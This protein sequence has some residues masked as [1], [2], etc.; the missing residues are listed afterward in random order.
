MTG[1]PGPGA[2]AARPARAVFFG[3]GPFGLAVLEAVRGHPGLSLVAVVSTPDRPSGRRAEPTP[4]PVSRRALELGLPLL[5]PERLR[6]PEATGA[7]AALAADLGVLADYGRI[8]PPAILDLP[9]HGILNVHPSLLP[10]HRGASPIAAAVLAADREAGVTVIRMDEGV[11]S[12]PILAAATIALTGTETAPELEA[13]LAD[14]GA[15]LFSR[16]VGRWLTGELTAEPQDERA[17]TMT[18]PFR[19]ADGAL[20]PT[21]PA[22]EL[23][24]RVRALAPW[25]GTFVETSQGRLLVD[26][27]TV[28]PAMAGDVAGT[29]VAEDAGLALATVDGRL[30]LDEVRLS[31]ARRMTGAELRRGRRALVGARALREGV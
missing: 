14:V 5:R 23:E 20:D 7:I 2:A 13:C 15:T 11:D 29:I 8:V 17:A 31:G 27:A 21:R 28:R 26:R 6:S 30:R 24:R 16:I 19:R 3:S 9:Q 10:R 1:E 25:P 12:G 18:R 22:A 4:T